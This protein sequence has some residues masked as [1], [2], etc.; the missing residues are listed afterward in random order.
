MMRRSQ[1]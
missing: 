1:L